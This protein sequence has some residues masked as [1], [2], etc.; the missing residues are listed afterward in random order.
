[1]KKCFHF[2]A[3]FMKQNGN[4]YCA[5]YYEGERVAVITVGAGECEETER[6]VAGCW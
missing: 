3:F 4:T 6:A 1:M 2:V 5:G